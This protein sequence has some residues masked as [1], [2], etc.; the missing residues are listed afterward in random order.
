MVEWGGV[1][2]GL[3]SSVRPVLFIQ[4]SKDYSIHLSIN[5]QLTQKVEYVLYCRGVRPRTICRVRHTVGKVRL[6]VPLRSPH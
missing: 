2:I 3:E 5:Q 4:W 6:V 1:F